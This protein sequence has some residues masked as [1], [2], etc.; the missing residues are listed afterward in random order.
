[1]KKRLAILARISVLFP[2]RVELL[3]RLRRKYVSLS[4]L[5]P[6]P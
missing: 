5:Q 3:E 2:A 1:M 4:Y 6:R